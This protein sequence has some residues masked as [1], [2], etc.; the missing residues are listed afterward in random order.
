MNKTKLTKEELSRIRSAA[1]KRGAD[2]LRKSGN[3]HGGRPKGATNKMPSG[4]DNETRSIMVREPAH[5][6][7]QRCANAAGR[8]L[9]DF[10]SLVAEAVRQKNPQLFLRDNIQL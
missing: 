8:S 9:V 6:I 7:F 2:A 1:G 5:A 3:Y 4:I 10:M